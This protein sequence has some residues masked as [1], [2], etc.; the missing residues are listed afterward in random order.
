MRGYDIIMKNELSEDKSRNIYIGN[1]ACED[2]WNKD[3]TIKLPK[4]DL[5]EVRSVIYN[6]E[7]LIIYLADPEDIVILRNL[8]NQD[9]IKQL[10]TL[11]IKI[12]K[13]V[14]PNANDINKPISELVLNDTQL[15]C[16]LKNY[17]NNNL[18]ENR[19]TNL[20]PYGVTE[21][22][23]KIAE[24]ISAQIASN[25][26]ICSRLN[27]KLLLNFYAKQMHINFPE[28]AICHG[29]YDLKCKGRIFLK[30]FKKVVV[31]EVYSSGG[32]GLVIIDC[33]EKLDQICKY[34]EGFFNTRGTIVLQRWYDSLLSYNHQYIITND[35]IIPH[36]FSKQVNMYQN[37]KIVGSIFNDIDCVGKELWNKHYKMSYILL[38]KIKEIGYRGII[39]FDSILSLNEKIFFPVID[40][41][42]R[43]NLSTIFG[44]ILS[45]YFNSRHSYFICREYV[46]SHPAAFKTIQSLLGDNEYSKRTKEGI[47][48]LNFASLN[49]N[50]LN[51][52]SKYGRIFYGIFA[53]TQSRLRE[54]QSFVVSDAMT[55]L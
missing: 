40:I 41:N 33:I 13:I 50:I 52:K 15:L 1:F 18:I 31:K 16:V 20:V 24:I 47:V 22:E 25:Y 26:L 5:K 51:A 7:E 39:G 28:T 30:K 35:S 32:S 6:L 9:F 55:I 37:G 14:T 36:C 4:L 17:V 2:I 19:K 49:Y 38:D 10:K 53:N 45:K 42:C 3:N 54:L 48:I 34:I 12:P 29:V 43:I 27:N 8:P 11:G 44:E 21:Y 23:N 46:L